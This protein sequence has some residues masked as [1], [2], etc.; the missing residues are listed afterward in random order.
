MFNRRLRKKSFCLR[1]IKSRMH[2][3]HIIQC[4]RNSHPARKNGDIS[5]EA[6]ITHKLI[7]LFPRIAPEHSQFAFI[8][9]EPE[10]GVERSCLA[11]AIR[12]NQA[13]NA[14]LFNSQI[15]GIERN[16]RAED[17]AKPACFY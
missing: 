3:R 15:H 13:E 7:A 17:L 14:A 8:W 9:G 1:A 12:T 4:L 6:N 16:R 2:A 11:C 10:N 5:N